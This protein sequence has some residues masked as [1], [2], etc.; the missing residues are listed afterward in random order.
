M[1]AIILPKRRQNRDRPF[2][3][4]TAQT[5]GLPEFDYQKNFDLDYQDLIIEVWLPEFD[6]YDYDSDL[7]ASIWP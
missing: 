6:F 1:A 3:I 4:I 2:A 5:F 7:M